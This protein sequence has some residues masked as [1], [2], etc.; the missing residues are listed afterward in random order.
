MFFK[1]FKLSLSVLDVVGVLPV[2]VAVVVLG[3]VLV[4]GLVEV[5]VAVNYK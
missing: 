5:V 4:D 3:V 2:V 1:N